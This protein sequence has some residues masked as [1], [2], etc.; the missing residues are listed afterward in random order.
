MGCIERIWDGNILSEQ[1]KEGGYKAS[2]QDY[3]ICN[4]S[5]TIDMD[6]QVG[7]PIRTRYI[8]IVDR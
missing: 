3:S 1:G 5:P 4:T 6:L 7:Q 8:V 2:G